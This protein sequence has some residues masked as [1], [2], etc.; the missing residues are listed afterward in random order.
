MVNLSFQGPI[1]VSSL[2]EEILRPLGLPGP[3][4]PPQAPEAGTLREQRAQIK[5]RLAEQ[6]RQ[7]IMGL[8]AAHRGNLTLTARALGLSRT[9]LYRKL[10]V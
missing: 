5:R 1:T 8:L 10:R 9:S 3:A 4:A 6:E 2:P 7:E